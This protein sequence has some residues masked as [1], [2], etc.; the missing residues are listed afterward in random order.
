[1]LFSWSIV[2][3]IGAI[4]VPVAQPD[5]P[6]DYSG[7]HQL[8]RVVAIME[9]DREPTEEDWRR[10]FQT[11]GYAALTRSEF[12]ESFFREQFN[13]VFMPSRQRELA[14]ALDSLDGWR[15]DYL[16][17]TVRVRDRWD[18][19]MAY[20][21]DPRLR[22]LIPE[23]R[24]RALQY[25][26]A[27]AATMGTPPVAFV[28]FGPDARGY[29]PV[30]M[31]ILAAMDQPD[32]VLFLGH[33]FHHHYRS[34]LLAYDR[35]AVDPGDEAILWV[36]DQLQ[37]EGTA[38]QVNRRQ[39]F[40]DRDAFARQQPGFYQDYL[41]S[42]A[43]IHTMDELL[44]RMEARPGK[45]T[46]LGHALRQAIPSSGHPTGFFMANLIADQL[47]MD[48]LIEEVGNPFAFLRRYHAAA[49][50]AAEEPA[51][52]DRPEA[53]PLS[54]TGLRFVQRLEQT[55]MDPGK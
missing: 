26:P 52:S 49:L 25:L 9:Q 15:Q 22:A 44:A 48:R 31:D 43:V 13:L 42:P 2:A 19:V 47:G 7:L 11:A 35:A 40:Q 3:F 14:E 53:P 41:N 10:L 1:M 29:V 36:F 51:R 33:E 18:E 5:P 30:V 38:N 55:Y 20:P 27:G 24:R 4:A 46:E 54:A 12:P 21:E 37:A 28:I 32:L 8:A 45:R 17:H 34:A 6:V 50:R 23:A 39:A 16:R